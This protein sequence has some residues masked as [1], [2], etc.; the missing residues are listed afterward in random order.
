MSIKLHMCHYN[1]D[2]VQVQLM[3]TSLNYHS[4]LNTFILDTELATPFFLLGLQTPKPRPTLE[5][6]KYSLGP[7]NYDF[8][9]DIL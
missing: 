8:V 2:P 6:L 1:S 9:R 7:Q 4:D 3:T 5:V